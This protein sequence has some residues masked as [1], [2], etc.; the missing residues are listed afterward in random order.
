VSLISSWGSVME[1]FRDREFST[2]WPAGA[3]GT[4]VLIDACG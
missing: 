2:V 3:Q 1:E 4:L